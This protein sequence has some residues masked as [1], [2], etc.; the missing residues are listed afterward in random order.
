M[1]ILFMICK[2]SSFVCYSSNCIGRQKIANYLS[3]VNLLIACCS[4]L[5][6]L[7]SSLFIYF[8]HFIL[9]TRT[10]RRFLHKTEGKKIVERLFRNMTNKF[11]L[12]MF[13]SSYTVYFFF[14]VH[15]NDCFRNRIETFSFLRAKKA[16]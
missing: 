14:L 4:F 12:R 11:M 15:L 9:Y 7:R 6:F 1:R 8:F 5:L 10:L 2:Y 16:R 3:I 13:M